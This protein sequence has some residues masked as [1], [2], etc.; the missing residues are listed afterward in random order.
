MDYQ[1]NDGG[2]AAAGFK[3]DT[4]DCV[5][6]AIAIAT[7]KP[8]EVV[9]KDLNDLARMVERKGKRGGKSSARTGVIRAT[10]DAYLVGLGAKWTP[11]MLIG[12]GC[13]VHLKADELPKGRLIVSLSRHLAAVIDGTVHDN[14][15]PR[16]GGTRCV[17]GY[18]T[19]PEERPVRDDDWMTYES[20]PVN[21]AWDH[22]TRIETVK[23]A[24]DRLIAGEQVAEV[25]ARSKAECERRAA[26]MTAA[27]ALLAA[28]K[29]VI[30]QYGNCDRLGADGF[31]L[32]YAAIEKAGRI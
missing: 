18:W 23:T 1:Y 22:V 13:K 31:G 6:R 2:R 12:A 3:G 27:P 4:R 30:A 25:Y 8:Y 10:Y 14:H 11:T 5:T 16:R 29:K 28:A 19:I 26:M 17:Y 21:S 15:D 32:L 20:V 24:A 9:Y 7:G